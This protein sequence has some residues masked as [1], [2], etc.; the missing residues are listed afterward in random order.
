M[1]LAGLEA[2]ATSVL[3]HFPLVCHVIFRSRALRR[4]CTQVIRFVHAGVAVRLVDSS[5][6]ALLTSKSA[7]TVS[8]RAS[9]RYRLARQRCHSDVEPRSRS[10]IPYSNSVLR[11]R[12]LPLAGLTPLRAFRFLRRDPPL[13]VTRAPRF[14]PPTPFAR[15]AL[16]EA[17]AEITV[18]PLRRRVLSCATAA[19]YTSSSLPCDRFRCASDAVALLAHTVAASYSSRVS[20]LPSHAGASSFD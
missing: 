17:S 4:R 13:Y 6:K 19:S 7:V 12:L 2:S 1:P 15:P 16:A 5:R 14:I 3:R 11:P 18:H 20:P 8:A 9:F 10:H